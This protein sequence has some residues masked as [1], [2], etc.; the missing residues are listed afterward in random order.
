ML[1]ELGPV[2]AEL[3]GAGGANRE[4]PLL[5]RRAG[6]LGEALLDGGTDFCGF[7]G[8]RAVLIRSSSPGSF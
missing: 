4:L 5:F 8:H 7:F 2:V 3:L 1:V 6:D